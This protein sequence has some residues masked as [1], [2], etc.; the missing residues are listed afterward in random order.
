MNAK[1]YFKFIEKCIIYGKKY[2][3]NTK[4]LYIKGKYATIFIFRSKI[5]NKY[6]STK[7]V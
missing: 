7:Y 2:R 3:E 4:S 6:Y 1:S 5:K